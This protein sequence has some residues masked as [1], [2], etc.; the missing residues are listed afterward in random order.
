MITKVTSKKELHEF[1]YFVKD[2]YK[3]DPY[4]V[5]PLFFM[6]KRELSKLV[7]NDKT[8][9][10]LL[11]KENDL[12]KGRLLYTIDFSK[13]QD[14]N[15]CYFNHFDCVN[16]TLVSRTLLKHMEEDMKTWGIDYSEGTFTPYDP[17]TR[18]GVMIKGFHQPPS[19]FTSYNYDYYSNLLED[20][21]YT[22]SIDTVLL[23]ALVN[24]DS[25]KKL[26]TF[27]KFF[28]R[29]HTINV[30]SINF[31]NLE[32]D[33]RDVKTILDIATNEIIYQD[34]PTYELIES[35]ANHMKQFI[36]PDFVKIAREPETDK[37]IGFCLVLPDFNQVLKKTNGKIRPLKMKILSKKITRARGMMQY[38]IPEYQSSGLIAHM[39]KCIFDEFEKYGITDFEAGTM[40]EDNPRPINLFKKFGGDII[41]IYRIYGKDVPK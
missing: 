39:F 30:D 40:M 35:A 28:T 10:A 12:V 34:A 11:Y 33:L 7:L 8:Y 20:F 18:R 32:R 24:E 5:Y 19:I 22:K 25:K 23:N 41:K 21:G 27:S 3:D 6:Q 13:K 31:K 4:Y 16:D 26:N 17:D 14:K 9:H 1:V 37:P 2:L 36:N 29:S 15:I 38:V